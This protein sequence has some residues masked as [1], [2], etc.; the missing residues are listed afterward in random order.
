MRNQPNKKLIGLFMAT[1]LAVLSIIFAIFIKNNFLSQN[2]KL[3]VMYFEESVNGLNVGSPVVFKGVQVG[4]VVRIEINAN[5]EDLTFSIPV[6]VKMNAS[7]NIKYEDNESMNYNLVSALIE[8]G[9]RARLTTQSYLTGQLMIELEMFPDTP[10]VMRGT[11]SHTNMIEIP[12][13]LSPLGEISKGLQD[14]PIRE[15]VV[16]FNQFFTSLNE[17]LPE[18]HKMIKSMSKSVNSN[19]GAAADTLDNLNKAA[20]NVSQA[21][22]ALRNFADYIERHP[23]ALLK[24]KR[25]E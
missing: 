23:E 17:E 22:K 9:L 25:D 4:K 14:L 11:K 5:P 16:K 21:A 13:V 24:G 1:G 18:I 10:V 7:H 3:L 8:K 6:Y 20:I 2:E 15:S 12:T 19:S